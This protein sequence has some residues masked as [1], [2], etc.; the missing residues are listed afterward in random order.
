MT[1]INGLTMDWLTTAWMRARTT[2]H[3]ISL[4]DEATHMIVTVSSKGD[5]VIRPEEQQ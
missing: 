2:E 5:V 1:H 4:V 3:A